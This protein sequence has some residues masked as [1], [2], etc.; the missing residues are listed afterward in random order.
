MTVRENPNINS[1][2]SADG[3]LRTADLAGAG[4][5]ETEDFIEVEAVPERAEQ[6]QTPLFGSDLTQDFRGQWQ[7]IQTGLSTNRAV[8]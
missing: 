1:N 6:E 7:N 4:K 8:R 2:P 3:K 5:T